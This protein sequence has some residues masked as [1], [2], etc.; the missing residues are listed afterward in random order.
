MKIR[1]KFVAAILSTVLAVPAIATLVPAVGLNTKA[2]VTVD[3]TK[4]GA[5]PNDSKDDVNAINS[6]ID[7]VNAKGGGTVTMPAGTFDIVLDDKY[8]GYGINLKDNVTLSMNKKTIL[9]V[10]GNN[11][12]RYSV[13][14]IRACSNVTVKGGQINGERKTHKGGFSED[15]YGINI[16]DAKNI[17]LEKMTIKDNLAD[18]IYIGTMSDTDSLYGCNKI[19]IK[20]C[21]VS[22]SGRNNIAIV[23]A[24]NVTIDKCTIK[25]AKGYNPQCGINIEPNTNGGKP[26]KDMICNKITIK[27][28]KVTCVGMGEDNKY[29]ALQIMNPYHY[30][31]SLNNVVAKNVKIDNCNLGGDVGNFSG[32]K[33]TFNKCKIKGTLYTKK[34]TKIKKTKYGSLEQY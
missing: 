5:I 8:G 6:A 31:S 21:T 9:K 34:P 30:D 13:I 26:A 28:T 7:D 4:Y 19:T 22:N 11:L 15:C 18:G 20:S 24:D 27:N 10:K 16:R 17:K 25:K 14:G 2:A 12:Q 29:F 23:D 1:N 3:V 32:S 33:V